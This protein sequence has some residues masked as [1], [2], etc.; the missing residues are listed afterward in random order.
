M[1]SNYFKTAWRN[2]WK[3]KTFS[4]INIAGLALGIA[5]FLL[6]MNYLRFQYSYDDYNVNKDRIYR[7][8]MEVV[9]KGPNVSK[10][11]KFAFT[12]PA[13]AMALKKDFPE[14][15]ETVR[16]RKQLSTRRCSGHF[17]LHSKKG[18]PAMCLPD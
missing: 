15:E 5:A 3:T 18:M 8:P 12:Y 17:L 6:I 9:E 1:L 4:S 13:V 2:I 11:Q 7:V 16:W 10:P 14:I